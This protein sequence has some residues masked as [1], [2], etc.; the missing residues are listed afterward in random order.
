V[1]CPVDIF[2]DEPI[3][4]SEMYAA[5]VEYDL[6]E[7][8]KIP[9]IGLEHLRQLKQAAGRPRDLLDLEELDQLSNGH[10]ER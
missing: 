5:R 10:E 8:L 3:E 7:A 9:V 6:K 1:D 4:F 2:V